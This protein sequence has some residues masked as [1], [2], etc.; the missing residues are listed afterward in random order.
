MLNILQFLLLI[1]R[2][3]S[4]LLSNITLHI[5]LLKFRINGRSISL[6]IALKIILLF[7]HLFRWNI[8]VQLRLWLLVMLPLPKAPPIVRL[9]MS[10]GWGECYWLWC[11]ILLPARECHIIMVF[12]IVLASRIVTLS[13]KCALS[14]HTPSW[15]NLLINRPFIFPCQQWPHIVALC[16]L[17]LDL[18]SRFRDILA[19]MMLIVMPLRVM[20]FQPLISPPLLVIRSLTCHRL[21]IIVIMTASTHGLPLWMALPV[22]ALA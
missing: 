13:I 2:W 22:V 17:L 21:S 11:F 3:T 1:I 16:M 8:L 19:P 9:F 15:A 12:I 5:L 4:L 20:F 18:V 10:G 6:V 7:Q 14:I